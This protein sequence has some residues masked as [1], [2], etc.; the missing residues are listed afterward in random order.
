MGGSRKLQLETD[1]EDLW[2]FMALVFYWMFGAFGAVGNLSSFFSLLMNPHGKRGDS[3]MTS[4]EETGAKVKSDVS[5]E[6][7][8]KYIV[9]HM[10]VHYE[11]V[12]L[13]SIIWHATIR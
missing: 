12:V 7:G 9:H 1:E 13:K 5:T 4:R 8:L 2:Q 6:V 11:E 3:G 10:Y